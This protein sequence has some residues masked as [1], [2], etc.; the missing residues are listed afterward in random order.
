MAGVLSEKPNLAKALAIDGWMSKG[1]MQ[2]L[3]HFA[4]ESLAILEVGSYKGR[5]A[6]AIADNTWGKVYCVD[7][8]LPD[9]IRDNGEKHEGIFPNVLSDFKENLKDL[10]EKDKVYVCQGNLTFYKDKLPRMDFAFIDGDHRY[11]EVKSDIEHCK[12]L[13]KHEGIIAGHD[14]GHKDWPGV[15]RAV[16]ELFDRDKINVHETIWWVKNE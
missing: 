7:P 8:W 5:S 13:V 14:W 16:L 2:C 10:I 4:R 3:A 15:Q 9:Y 11:E 6:R 12:K 1:E